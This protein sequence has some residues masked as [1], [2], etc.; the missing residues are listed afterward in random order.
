[1]NDYRISQGKATLGF[2]NPWLYST[3]LSGNYCMFVSVI[4]FSVAEVL[5]MLGLTDITSGNNPGCGTNGFSARE[6]WDP[7]TVRTNLLHS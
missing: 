3:G 4:R 2:L 7:I 1:L 6:G 5:L